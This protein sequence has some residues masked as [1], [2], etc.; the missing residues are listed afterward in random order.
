MIRLSDDLR[1][2]LE[3]HAVRDYPYECCGAIL[4]DLAGDEKTVRM[5][6]ALENVHEDGHERRFLISPEQ[7]FRLEQDS[8]SN[9]LKILGFYHSH[10]DHPARP[11][12]YDR[13]WA[14]PWYSYIILSV[15]SG[16]PAEM[17]C[18]N[19]NEDRGSFTQEP[20]E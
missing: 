12:E 17:T 7:M 1:R 6:K 15:Q 4:G 11:S 3:E 9:G 14:W 16:K 20:L 2:L 13:E 18:W 10:P 8:R 19:L 5:L